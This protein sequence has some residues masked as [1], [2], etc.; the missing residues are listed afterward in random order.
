[1]AG[2]LERQINRAVQK[3]KVT[4]DSEEEGRMRNEMR[5]KSKLTPL[6]PL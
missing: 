4:L 5:N 2:R 3:I 6:V 1:V